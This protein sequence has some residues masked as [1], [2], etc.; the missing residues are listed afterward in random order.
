MLLAPCKKT[1]RGTPR[2][3]MYVFHTC[4]EGAAHNG[5]GFTQTQAEILIEHVCDA[6]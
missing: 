3:C 2:L 6:Q 4:N 5:A 1:F